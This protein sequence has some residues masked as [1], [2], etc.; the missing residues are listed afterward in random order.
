MFR[1][2]NFMIGHPGAVDNAVPG[3]LE[4][5]DSSSQTVRD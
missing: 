4:K 5:G 1:G 2:E 3:C